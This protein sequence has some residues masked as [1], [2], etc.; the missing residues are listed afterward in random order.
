[1]STCELQAHEVTVKCDSR[2][3]CSGNKK[4]CYSK[5]LLFVAKPVF[6]SGPPRDFFNQIRKLP[7]GVFTTEVKGR[8]YKVETQVILVTQAL[9]D[10]F[11]C[12]C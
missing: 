8:E 11:D 7:T 2:N 4:C 1:M 9:S 5:K 12:F 3:F 6:N 10:Y